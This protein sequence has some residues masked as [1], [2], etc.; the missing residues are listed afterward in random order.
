MMSCSLIRSIMIAAIVVMSC[1]AYQSADNLVGLSVG[2]IRIG[3]STI[4]DVHSLF[5]PAPLSPLGT[6]DGMDLAVCYENTEDSDG[7]YLTFETNTFGGMK[8]VTALQMSVY[9]PSI[10]C[11]RTEKS[12]AR[13]ETDNGIA[14]GQTKSSFVKFFPFEFREEDD[15]LIFESVERREMTREERERRKMVWPGETDNFFDVT[16]TIIGEFNNE[17]L[18]RY[19]A[20]QIVSY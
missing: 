6:Q 1:V 10:A 5:G 17:R 3:E 20:S 16:T 9:Q 11:Q 18:I 4:L 19:Y 14:L 13:F 8:T 15:H 2:S 7:L 12:I